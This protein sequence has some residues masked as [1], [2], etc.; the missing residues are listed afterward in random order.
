M[1]K[2]RHLIAGIVAVG[3]M[4]GSAAHGA[5]TLYSTTVLS[6]HPVVYW[7]LDEADGNAIQQA[8]LTQAPVTTENDLVPVGSPGR[9]SHASIADGLTKLG[10]AANFNGTNFFQA[11]ALRAGKPLLT[12]AYAIE[13]WMQVQG[14]N[15]GDRQDYLVNF[16]PVGGDNAPALIYDFKPDQLELFGGGSRTDAG[17]TISDALWHHVLLVYYGDG[18]DGVADRVDAYLDGVDTPGIGN[19]FAKRLNLARVLVGAALPSG[20]NGFEGRLDEVA[21]YDLS[22]LADET[23]VTTK[24]A[25]MATSHFAEAKSAS[26]TTY[27]SVVLQDQPLLYWNFDETD[28]NAMQK[29]PITFGELDNTIND[30]VPA[31]NATR[32]SHSAIASGLQLGNAADLDG[33]GSY[34]GL[35]TG[36]SVGQPVVAGPW[37]LELWFQLRGNQSQ[38]YLLNMGQNANSPAVIY[39]YFGS[40]LE[41]YGTT[42]GRSGTNGAVVADQNWHHLFIVNYNNA[43]GTMTPGA[44]YNRVDFYID[45][46]LYP[47]VGGGFNTPVDFRGWLLFGA[48]V[49][50]PDPV[51]SG[52]LDGRIDELAIYDLSAITNAADLTAKTSLM[53]SNHYAAAFGG[54]TIGTITISEQPGDVTA[55]R[56]GTAT[57]KVTASLAG[58]TAPLTYQWQRNGVSIN[59]ATNSTYVISAVSINDI[60]TNAYRARVGAGPVFKFSNTAN[61]IVPVPAPASPTFY[62]ATVLAD[63]PFLYWNFDESTGPSVQQAALVSVPVTTEND[64]VPT[65]S[66]ATRVSHADLSDGLTK[67]GKA[68]QLDGSSF[69]MSSSLRLSKMVLTGAYATEVWVKINGGVNEYLANFG[70]NN[71]ALI[72]AFNAS[73]FEMYGPAGRTGTNGPAVTDNNWHHL[74]WVNYNTAPAASSNRVD[75]FLDGVLTT[76]VGGGFNQ[77]LSLNQVVVGAALASGVNGVDG[78]LDEL[79]VYDLSGLSTDQAAVKAASIATNHFAASS[80]LSSAIYSNLVLS[81]NP[82]LYYNFDEA[83]GNALQKAPVV[84]PSLNNS[85]NNMVA[86]DA[87]RAEHSVLNDGLTLGN[88]VQ[89]DG[90]SFFQAATLD[91]GKASLPAP[92]AVEFWMQVDGPNTDNRQDY[93]LNFGDNAPAFIYDFKPD[94]LEIFTGVRTDNGPVVSDNTWH[95]VM[96]VFYG[97][98]TVGV[99]DRVDAYLDGVLFPGIRA[100]FTRALSLG[101][102]LIVGAAQPG[103]NGFEGR[104]DEVA[105]Y[106]LSSLGSE[107]AITSKITQMVASHRD[108]STKAPITRPS[109]SWSRTGTQLTLSWEGQG[110]VLQENAKVIDAAGWTN[111]AGGA[112]SPT[113]ITIGDTGGKFYRLIKP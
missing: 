99:A 53:A 33:T 74:V 58:S 85:L 41:V 35:T 26:G 27:A 113:T 62:S 18:T 56:G 66:A 11:T 25:A 24:V 97:D 103:Y 108:A 48:A 13:L 61:L 63:K 10:N 46:T 1:M 34:F 75:A 55:S 65:G 29:A 15:S 80:N 71:P 32:I 38:R 42:L 21:V 102:R 7:N 94:Q 9:V 16:G 44:N 3:L 70:N 98:G 104:L 59:G 91:T 8:P 83:E 17:P 76:N 90:K 67:L 69:L 110:F 14:D 31:F 43:P 87:L 84:L 73:Y 77:T 78:Y 47:N 51:Q 54:G 101:G 81:D 37:A 45:N 106:D 28:G 12:G 79:A 82:I 95:H 92:W 36:L 72:Y 20:V 88:A 30:L 5:A 50:N 57:F 107:S 22:S 109:L 19:L 105:I 86:A 100:D 89:F 40:S 23:A 49:P 64:L 111:V 52:S 93:L 60:G 39:G 96:W 4:V 68:V 112:S 6:D 2:T